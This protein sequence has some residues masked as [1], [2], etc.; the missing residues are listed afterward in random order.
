MGSNL[1]LK[2]KGLFLI[3]LIGLS[4][5]VTLASPAALATQEG[6]GVKPQPAVSA[7]SAKFYH[8]TTDDGL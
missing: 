2:S 3:T 1:H 6:D 5:F 4:L 8:L 7:N